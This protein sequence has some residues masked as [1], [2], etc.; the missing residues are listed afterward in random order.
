MTLSSSS[1]SLSLLALLAFLL[2]LEVAVLDAVERAGA[3]LNCDCVDLAAV[4][5][6]AVGFAAAAFAGAVGFFD[7][8]FRDASSSSSAESS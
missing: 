1:S 8:V 4:F 2:R 6:P 7:T 3:K 5:L